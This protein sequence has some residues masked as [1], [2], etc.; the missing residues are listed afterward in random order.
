[1]IDLTQLTEEQ[2]NE[3]ELQIQKHKEQEKHKDNP[4]YTQIENEV[5]RVWLGQPDEPESEYV[6]DIHRSYIPELIHT[7][8][9]LK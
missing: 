9:N 1:M 3:L 2:L 8:R 5:V 7:L 4:F 6:M